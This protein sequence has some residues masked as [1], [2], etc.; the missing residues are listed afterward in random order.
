MKTII[1]YLHHCFNYMMDLIVKRLWKVIPTI[2]LVAF[3]IT[4]A[5]FSVFAKLNNR[6][7]EVYDFQGDV[8]DLNEIQTDY[9]LFDSRTSN[10]KTFKKVNN[11]YELAIYSEDIHYL[12][13]GKYI[14]TLAYVRV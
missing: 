4:F 13:N 8:I 5:D 9:E 7:E 3:L 10:T 14:E 11:S 6:I 12:D 1:T 2:L